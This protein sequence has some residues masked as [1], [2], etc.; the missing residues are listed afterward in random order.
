M[1]HRGLRLTAVLI[2]LVVLCGVARAEFRLPACF[3]DHMVL[4]QGRPLPVWGT[5]GPAEEV[6]VRFGGA[7]VTGTAGSDGRWRVELPPQ[8]SSAEGRPLVVEGR[9]TI[10]LADVLVGEVWLC[11]G[12]SNMLLPLGKADRSAAVVAAADDPLLRLLP[13]AAAAGGDPPPY[14]SAEIAAL[15]PETFTSGSWVRSSP[16]AARSFSAVAFFFA[17]RLRGE[18]GVPVGVIQVAVG[19]SPTEAW[20]GRASLASRAETAGFTQGPWLR[21]PLVG[22]WCR[23]RAAAN[24]AR[25]VKAGERIPGDDL[26]PNHPFKPGFLREAAIE[27]LVPLALAGVC[28]YQGESNAETPEL[29]MLHERLFPALVDDW[30]RGWGRDDLPFGVVQLPGLGRPHWPAFRDGQRRLQARLPHTGLAVAIDLGDRSDVHPRDKQ[31]IGDRLAGWALADVYGRDVVGS[32]PLPAAARRQ[33]DGRV[34]VEFAHAAGGLATAD[35][36]PPRHFEIA[37]AD[38]VFRPA[39]ARIDGAAVVLAPTNVPS[40]RVRYAWR[41]FP[42]PPVNL[43]GPGGLPVTPFD[44]D[45]TPGGEP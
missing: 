30:R 8:R 29:V 20:I 17:R 4:Q 11:A 7:V 39:E 10:T 42:E 26:G 27:P 22:E 34:R 43:V 31:P 25:A 38:E 21:N 28:W 44:L 5:A 24:L 2:G 35:G 15:Q 36:E 37:G 19:G 18:L 6:R 3:G 23:T 13:L 12:Q 33:G 32:S 40:R 41:P 1:P 16:A 9:T 14:S 45:V